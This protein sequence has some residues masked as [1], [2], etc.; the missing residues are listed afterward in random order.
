MC[1]DNKNMS[2]EIIAGDCSNKKYCFAR[3]KSLLVWS[4]GLFFLI[5][6]VSK[7]KHSL[8][9]AFLENVKV[10]TQALV[11]WPDEN[12]KPV[13]TSDYRIPDVFQFT[14]EIQRLQIDENDFFLSRI[15]SQ[16]SLQMN[17]WIKP[18]GTWL[19]GRSPTFF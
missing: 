18:F 16:R 10:Q 6:S 12:L 9:P 15:M 17:R 5:K 13:S 3:I 19:K 7:I 4:F 1:V 11:K 8:P 14:E 2:D